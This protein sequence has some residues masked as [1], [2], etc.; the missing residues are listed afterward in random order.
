MIQHN[1]LHDDRE[2][3]R[4]YRRRDEEQTAPGE[5]EEE[6]G[7]ENEEDSDE[8]ESSESSEE[9]EEMDRKFKE[10]LRTPEGIAAVLVSCSKE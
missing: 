6:S 5:E 3:S 7:D 8:D 10:Y 9:K 4:L 1:A 2:I